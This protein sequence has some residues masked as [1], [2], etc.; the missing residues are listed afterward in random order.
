MGFSKRLKLL[1]KNADVT[2]DELA[3]YLQV[4][5]ST[6]AGYETKNRQPDYDKLYMIA[7]FFHVSTDYLISGSDIRPV[8]VSTVDSSMNERMLKYHLRTI[9]AT[10]SLKSKQD[11]LEYARLL[12]MRDEIR[13]PSLDISHQHERRNHL[14]DSSFFYVT[15]SE[16]P[17]EPHRVSP[18]PLRSR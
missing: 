16:S 6:I 8:E 2:Q 13:W 18:S 7:Q 1:R 17:Q 14:F 3:Q 15:T 11:L 10:L 5:R 4:S 9:Y 12:A